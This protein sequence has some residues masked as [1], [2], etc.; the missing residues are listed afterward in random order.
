[1]KRSLLS[2]LIKSS[3][4]FPKKISFWFKILSL[5]FNNI[6]LLGK[7]QKEALRTKKAANLEAPFNVSIW[8]GETLNCI[9]I[10]FKKHFC[11]HCGCR[12]P[13]VTVHWKHLLDRFSKGLY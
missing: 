12:P 5:C 1:M 9:Q 8:K 7:Y 3:V 2:E 11:T 4:Y 10:N 6:I 13:S